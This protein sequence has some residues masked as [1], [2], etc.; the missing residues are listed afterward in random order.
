MKY[1]YYEQ[2]NI[3]KT[4][5][6]WKYEKIVLLHLL[7]FKYILVVKQY[8]LIKGRDNLRRELKLVETGG[9]F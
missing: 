5:C 4:A 6:D 1:W 7:P 8:I 2:K 3:H 9:F